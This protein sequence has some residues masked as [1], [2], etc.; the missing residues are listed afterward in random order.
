[1]VR[2][3]ARSRTM[4]LWFRFDLLPPR[5]PVKAERPPLVL[6]V[7]PDS[8]LANGSDEPELPEAPV[9]DPRDP[10][11]P[12]EEE[13]DSKL[14]SGS[15]EPEL[16]DLAVKELSDPS[17]DEPDP[18]PANGS[19]EPELPVKEPNEPSEEE[20]DARPA[21]VTWSAIIKV[22]SKCTVVKAVNP[23]LLV[24]LLGT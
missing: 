9:S 1:M 20:L 16:P 21:A 13:P 17:E 3:S 11:E 7:E 23:L 14:A 12:R 5:I 2:I 8:K 10:N 19:D 6:P 24:I 18:R 22:S 15:D 4:T